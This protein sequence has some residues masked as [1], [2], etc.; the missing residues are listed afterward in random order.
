MNDAPDIGKYIHK[1]LEYFEKH[2]QD[3]SKS[4]EEHQ[5]LDHQR[6]LQKQCWN[7]FIAGFKDGFLAPVKFIAG[8][9][10]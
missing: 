9:F 7:A 8:L 4:P 1:A 10:R 3:P 5:R 2:L 6:Q